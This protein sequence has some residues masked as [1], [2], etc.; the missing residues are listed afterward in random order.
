MLDKLFTRYEELYPELVEIRRELHRNPEI[1]NEEV[2]TPKKIAAYLTELGLDVRTGVGGRGVV[3]YLKGGK[4][5]KTIA[6]RADFDALPIQDEK[7]VE[8][9]SQ[10]A[11]AMHACGHDLHTATLLGVAKVLSEIKEEIPGTIVF[12][13]QFAEEITPGGAQFMIEDGC[14]DGVDVVYGAHVMS[15]EPVGTAQVIEGYASSAQDDFYVE[16]QGVG[17]HGA[18]PHMTVDA[19]VTA[20]QLV[21]NYQQII[22]RRVSPMRQA[23]LTVG[24]IHSGSVTNIIPDTASL[25]GTVRTFDEETRDVIE[26]A[27]Q[28]VTTSTCEAAGATVKF[29]YI[30][31]CPSIFNDATETDRIREVAKWVLGTEN[32]SD[33]EKMTGSEDFAFYQQV[34]PGT[35]FMVGGGNP[36]LNAVYPHHHPKFDVDEMSI[37]HIG[38]IFI[39]GAL[40]YLS[41][42]EIKKE[43]KKNSV[44]L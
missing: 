25:K 17:G 42:G 10:V 16:V 7:Q 19:L 30:R 3:G 22:S 4:P 13:H 34:V 29:N 32:V 44:L 26:K 23:A 24:A 14:L 9:K 20:C 21:V 38:K 1:S 31:D 11:G 6:L 27:M 2:E 5:G 28:Q 39:G 15:H 33:A 36:Q 35:Y 37:Q 40:N 18:S 43:L 41:D 12:L 8:Y